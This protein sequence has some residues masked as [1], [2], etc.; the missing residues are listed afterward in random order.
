M[1]KISFYKVIHNLQFMSHLWIVQK[2][3]IKKKPKFTSSR[4]NACF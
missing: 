1:N 3:E 2:T 4:K